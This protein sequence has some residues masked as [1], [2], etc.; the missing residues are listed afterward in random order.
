MERRVEEVV[1]MG[2]IQSR[3]GNA[4]G[5]VSSQRNAVA[6]NLKLER[7]AQRSPPQQ[8]DFFTINQTHFHQSH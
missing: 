6:T 5:L 2:S 3:N 8:F 1:A 4:P 7:I